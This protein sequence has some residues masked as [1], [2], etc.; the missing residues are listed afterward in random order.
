MS[1]S[2]CAATLT[3]T[4]RQLASCRLF[5]ACQKRGVKKPSCC[6][7]HHSIISSLTARIDTSPLFVSRT[8]IIAPFAASFRQ[9]RQVHKA[10]RIVKT[11][12]RFRALRSF[13]RSGRVFAALLH[14]ALPQVC[15]GL[16]IMRMLI[17]PGHGTKPLE[18]LQARSSHG[19]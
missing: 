7:A 10:G 15:T 8:L 6:M 12:L 19:H 2:T 16:P 17:L 3:A 11:R 9:L 1:L 13:G 4:P 14:P 5:A 18:P